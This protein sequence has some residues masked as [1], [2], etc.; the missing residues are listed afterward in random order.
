MMRNYQVLQKLGITTLASIV[1]HS[2]IKGKTAA[3]ED[4]DCLYEPGHDEDV[5]GDILDEVDASINADCPTQADAEIHISNEGGPTV[6]RD[7]W[8]RGKSMGKHLDRLSRGLN[9]KIPVVVAEG[10]KRPDA[11]MQAAKLASESGIIVRQHVPIY[12]HWKEYKDD[13][14]TCKDYMDKIAATFSIDINNQAVKYACIDLLKCRQR[15][16]RHKLKKAFFDG[17]PANQVTT[18]SPVNTM[19]DD[20]WQALVD[21]WS[22]PKHKE[23]CVKAK[24][25]RG[26]VQFG[27]KTGSRSFIAHAHVKAQMEAIVA[28]P[29]EEGQ[30]QKTPLEAVAHVL[31]SSSSFLQNVGLAQAGPKRSA[32]SSA[33]AARVQELEAEVEAEKKGSAVLRD[34]VDSQQD[35]LEALKKKSEESEEARQKQA[36]E[37]ENLKKQAEESKKQ[38]E[39]TNALLRR[40]LSLNRE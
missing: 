29:A 17:I 15:N 9:T 1:N 11:P 33:A 31:P 4:S 2:T 14:A 18:T 13:K 6:V 23:K 28:E 34:K 38:P 3:R 39:E 16:M 26:N 32:K 22:N 19:T 20:Q 27:Q 37:I 36:E 12:T 21:M 8:T 24:Q 40:L 10:K 30:A 35:E 5:E 7:G 25:S